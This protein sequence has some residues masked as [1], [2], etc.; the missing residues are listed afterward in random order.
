MNIIWLY[1]ILY[2]VSLE[3]L[4]NMILRCKLFFLFVK[5]LI[6]EVTYNFFKIVVHGGILVFEIAES[7]KTENHFPII[8][9]NL[10]FETH[11]I[12]YTLYIIH[13]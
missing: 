10:N 4:V 5:K 6:L 12:I 8:A 3:S 7:W 9:S 11:Q 2:S 13:I 1:I